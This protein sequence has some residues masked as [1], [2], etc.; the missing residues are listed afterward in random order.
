M[1][2]AQQ[3]SKPSAPEERWTVVQVASYLAISYQTAR[4]NML[5]GDFGLSAYDAETRTLTVPAAN[6]R[7]M[8]AALKKNDVENMPRGEYRKKQRKYVVTTPKKSKKHT[9]RNPPTKGD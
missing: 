7:A 2:N 1:A 8:K 4:N 5:A 9:R 6:V 3:A